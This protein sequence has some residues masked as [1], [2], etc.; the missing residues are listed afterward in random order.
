MDVDI[1]CNI[2][3]SNSDSYV[4]QKSGQYKAQ[5]NFR[6]ISDKSR[7]R[8]LMH[9]FVGQRLLRNYWRMSWNAL[10]KV[11]SETNENKKDDNFVWK[12]MEE[13]AVIGKAKLMRSRVVP[14][15]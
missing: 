12:S 11:Q 5:V 7:F 10:F 1:F 6:D 9:A 14:S 2:P 8:D 13:E 15:Q 4:L 3:P